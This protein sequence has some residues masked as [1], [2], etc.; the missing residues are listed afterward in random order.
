[1]VSN[2]VLKKKGDF[3]AGMGLFRISAL[4]LIVGGMCAVVALVLLR[5]IDFFT[6]LFYFQRLSFDP[7]NPADNHLYALA[8]LVPAVGGFVIGLMARFGSE[9]FAVM[10]FPKRWRP[11]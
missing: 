6:N 7:A 9:R 4:A 1:M 5:L 2:D 3:T 10:A 8:I 11:S